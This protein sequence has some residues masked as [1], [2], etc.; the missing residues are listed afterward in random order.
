VFTSANSGLHSTPPVILIVAAIRQ[1][2]FGHMDNWLRLGGGGVVV[3]VGFG[4]VV[5]VVTSAAVV[6]MNGVVLGMRL[7]TV[8]TVGHP[9]KSVVFL[10][11]QPPEEMVT[12]GGGGVSALGLSDVVG[13]VTLNPPVFVG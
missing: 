9:V 3:V 1:T 11:G 13:L 10:V 12:L 2:S 6:L 7:F 4:V 5:V 8:D